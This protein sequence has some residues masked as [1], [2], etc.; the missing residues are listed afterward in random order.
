M[1][2]EIVSDKELKQN[3]RERQTMEGSR[4]QWGEKR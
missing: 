4:G 2:E 3:G 1:K